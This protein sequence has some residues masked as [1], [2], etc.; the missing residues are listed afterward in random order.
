MSERYRPDDGRPRIW[1]ARL[2]VLVVAVLGAAVATVGGSPAYAQGPADVS[3]TVS[4]N[5][6]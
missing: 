4:G 2:L 6:D 1:P 3:V 5:P